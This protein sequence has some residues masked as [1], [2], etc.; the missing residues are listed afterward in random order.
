MK[1]WF[2][3]GAL[4]A[5]VVAKTIEINV[6]SIPLTFL[7]DQVAAD[8]GDVLEFHFYPQNHSVVAGDYDSPCTPLDHGGFFSGFVPVASGESEAVFKVTVNHTNP[9]FFYCSQGQHCATGMV[10]VVNPT[11]N[12]TLMAYAQNAVG[13]TSFSPFASEAFGSEFG[14]SS[15]ENDTAD[16]GY[17]EG[18]DGQ[19]QSGDGESFASVFESSGLGLV[20][21]LGLAMLLACNM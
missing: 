9:M 8:V 3:G 16:G 7:P 1:H 2:V 5:Q 4:A 20:G 13:W 6:A 11:D 14:S 10:G 21:S 18:S 19:G 12:Q 17:G 15:S